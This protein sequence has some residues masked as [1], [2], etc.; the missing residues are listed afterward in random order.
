MQEERIFMFVDL[1][2]S[3]TIAEVL[4]DLRYSRMLQD[5]FAT[6]GNAILAS[7]AEVYQYAGDEI[8]LTWKTA[9]G[10]KDRRCLHCF[11]MIIQSIRQREA[12]FQSE[13]GL[14][15]EFKAGM[16]LGTAVT[17]WVGTIK[18][19]IAYH[20]DLLNTTARIQSKCN[21]LGHD[22]IISEAVVKRV[23]PGSEVS[24]SHRGSIEL[25]GKSLP[26]ELYSVD[27]TK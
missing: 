4:G 2:S 5:L 18:K 8:I 26:L 11:D 25:R 7:R 12:Y 17:A 22:F 15:P 23:S 10:L 14:I 27:F 24:Y 16:H 19:E 21:E 3:T 9:D 13:Y 6:M 1:R 20:G